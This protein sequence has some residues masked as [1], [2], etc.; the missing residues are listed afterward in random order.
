MAKEWFGRKSLTLNS[1]KVYIKV[2]NPSDATLNGVPLVNL[3]SFKRTIVNDRTINMG[4][5]DIDTITQRGGPITRTTFSIEKR[6]VGPGLI[7]VTIPRFAVTAISPPG[8][9]LELNINVITTGMTYR[10]II[11]VVI[12]NDGQDRYGMATMTNNGIKITFLDPEANFVAPFEI[13]GDITFVVAPS[14]SN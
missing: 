7:A 1:E 6:Q 3:D 13:K 14:A 11:P 12:T 8:E 9:N 10:H 2:N 5:S 4:D